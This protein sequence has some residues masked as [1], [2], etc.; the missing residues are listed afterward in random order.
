MGMVSDT[1]GFNR[2]R[3][4]TSAAH[5]FEE[6]ERDRQSRG[7][8]GS[9]AMANEEEERERQR[10]GKH[11]SSSVSYEEEER[12]RRENQQKARINNRK[13]ELNYILSDSYI[14][15]RCEDIMSKLISEVTSFLSTLEC[16]KYSQLK[17]LEGEFKLLT[18]LC[19]TFCSWD[20]L[21][22]RM[23]K[24]NP[25]SVFTNIS[26][27]FQN[28]NDLFAKSLKEGELDSIQEYLNKSR[29]S[30]DFL[31][32]VRN[33]SN[34][35]K[36][37]PSDSKMI[38][39]AKSNF[40]SC[41]SYTDLKSL[42]IRDIEA[43]REMTVIPILA[44]QEILQSFD[45][46]DNFYKKLSVVFTK[47]RKIKFIQEHLDSKSVDATT[48]EE[49]GRDFFTKN[50]QDLQLNLLGDIKSFPKDQEFYKDFDAKY[51]NLRSIITNLG[52]PTMVEQ[53]KIVLK[54]VNRA[55]ESQF[56]SMKESWP[57]ATKLTLADKLIEMKEIAIAIPGL[58]DIVNNS[59]DKY[60]SSLEKFAIGLLGAELNVHTNSTVAR[61]LINDTK[62]L[63]S[64]S[65]LLK[66]E[67]ISKFTYNDVLKTISA[68]GIKLDTK[69]LR[70]H[71]EA[72]E[73][74]Y[75]GIVNDGLG[76]LENIDNI[77]CDN[78]LFVIRKLSRKSSTHH[79][80]YLWILDTITKVPSHPRLRQ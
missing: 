2:G 12:Q 58:K 67:K 38:S 62:S 22:Q 6:E 7:K 52:I 28:L 66:N 31:T 50:L 4:T 39:D 18:Q 32:V 65:L 13:R 35:S 54:L 80:S 36:V 20:S 55:L 56:N 37:T 76:R 1:L 42:L 44:N 74:E 79:C 75:D 61:A 63:Q 17:K 3:Q 29:E 48:M 53:T 68:D 14:K 69:G 30:S 10:R 27:C 8:H 73:K 21:R 41:K 26:T 23:G 71:Y 34:P 64:Y 16:S 60:I 59:I 49:R 5:S 78:C 40:N 47:L 43:T 51:D 45:K 19:D 77:S 70:D 46:R 24:I 9:S 15:R 57:K 33:Y 25:F 72:F 11:G